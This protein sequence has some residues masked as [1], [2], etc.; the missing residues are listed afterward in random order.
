MS[1]SIILDEKDIECISNFLDNGKG[2]IDDVLI[3]I[4][5]QAVAKK[6]IC[7]HVFQKNSSIPACI[8]CGKIK[9]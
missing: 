9:E 2:D 3:E 5:T 1:V 8:L 7:R 6:Q 4:T